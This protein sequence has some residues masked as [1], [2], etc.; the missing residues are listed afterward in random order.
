MALSIFDDRKAPPTDAAI[1]E[2][3]GRSGAAWSRLKAELT[4]ESAL[5]E[6]WAFAGAKFGWSLRLKRGK[7]V[8]VYMTPCTGHFLASFV[9]GEKACAA[10]SEAGLPASILAAIADAPRYAEGRGFRIP[11]RA[12]R[13]IPG[14][15]KLAAIK[16]AH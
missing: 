10:A 13:E 5:E 15:L 11:V 9:L 1:E 7:R 4:G 6:E 16:L 3:L 8:I 14:L 12:L 2:A